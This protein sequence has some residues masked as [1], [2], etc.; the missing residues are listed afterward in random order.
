MVRMATT[1]SCS[2]PW[3]TP[4]QRTCETIRGNVAVVGPAHRHCQAQANPHAIQHR[5]STTRPSSDCPQLPSRRTN[6]CRCCTRWERSC[7]SSQ[8][9]PPSKHY[10]NQISDIF[11]SR[12]T[13][14]QTQHVPYEPCAA[15]GEGTVLLP[16]AEVVS[17]CG[18]VS[19]SPSERLRYCAPAKLS[20]QVPMNGK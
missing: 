11:G 12:S 5:L 20:Q 8:L 13:P 17:A 2:I 4:G 3:F 19:P 18:G 7:V 10:G 9:A 14:V 6:L 1:P 16:D 15:V